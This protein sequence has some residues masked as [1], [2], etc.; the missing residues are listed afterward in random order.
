M[1]RT[2]YRAALATLGWSAR[3]LARRLGR[4]E[5]TVGQWHKPGRPD[6]PPWAVADWL[7]RAAAA[8]AAW[9]RDNP[10]PG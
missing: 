7:R 10:P 5:G 3:E 9:V 6:N 8:H 1:N 2:E 4:P